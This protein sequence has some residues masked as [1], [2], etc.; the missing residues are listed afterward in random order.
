M[1]ANSTDTHLV[2]YSVWIKV[3][4]KAARWDAYS[5]DMMARTTAATRVGSMDEHWAAWTAACWGGQSVDRMEA[6]MAVPRVSLSAFRLVATRVALMAA[7]SDCLLVA[8][9]RADCWVDL[10]VGLMDAS[11][12]VLKDWRRAALWVAE[13]ETAKAG[14]TVAPMGAQ[15]TA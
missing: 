9:R 6:T 7:H 12:V 5:A 15:K 13:T 11:M 1:K 3:A 4:K 2:G 8:R 14:S 10:M